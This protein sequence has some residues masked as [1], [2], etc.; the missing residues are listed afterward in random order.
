MWK[1]ALEHMFGRQLILKLPSGDIALALK[2]T[3][4]RPHSVADRQYSL[5]TVLAVL[6]SL[7]ASEV[8]EFTI[9]NL[10]LLQG[11]PLLRVHLHLLCVHLQEQPHQERPPP[12]T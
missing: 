4:L 10:F 7:C 2:A 5:I 6:A 3:H 12:W 1:C 11:H 8:A 9:C